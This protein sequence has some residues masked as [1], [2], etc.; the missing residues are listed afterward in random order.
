MDIFSWSWIQ[1]K[2]TGVVSTTVTPKIH[3]P[4]L[5]N[6]RSVSVSLELGHVVLL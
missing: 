3:I 4:L 2:A 6:S 1:Q 5:T